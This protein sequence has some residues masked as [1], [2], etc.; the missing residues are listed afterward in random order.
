VS[1]EPRWSGVTTG[2]GQTI[3]VN[4]VS[5]GTYTLTAK[6]AL[7]CDGGKTVTIK[8]KEPA[9]YRVGFNGDHSK[10]TGKNLYLFA[11]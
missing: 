4:F 6:C 7:A 10:L 2:T 8:V 5:T 9:V 11:D 3:D 1:G